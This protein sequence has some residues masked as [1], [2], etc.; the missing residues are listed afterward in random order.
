MWGSARGPVDGERIEVP[1]FRVPALSLSRH[2]P[3][4]TA[5][6]IWFILSPGTADNRYGGVSGAQRGGA[7]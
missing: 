4:V 5:L 1:P 3:L 2:S 7:A 6:A